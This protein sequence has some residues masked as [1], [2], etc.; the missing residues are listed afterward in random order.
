M[1]EAAD[2][3]IP[4]TPKNGGRKIILTIRVSRPSPRIRKRRKAISDD[5]FPKTQGVKISREATQCIPKIL[6]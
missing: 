1:K 6:T 5:S 4:M 2:I 3:D